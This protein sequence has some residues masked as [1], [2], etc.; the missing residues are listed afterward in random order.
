MNFIYQYNILN[1]LQPSRLGHNNSLKTYIPQYIS[2]FKFENCNVNYEFRIII[3]TKILL[4][5]IPDKYSR[6][7]Y[8]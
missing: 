2:L 3:D 6:L 7:L 8:F 4:K 5:I 1:Q